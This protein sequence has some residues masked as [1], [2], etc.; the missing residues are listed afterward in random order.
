M[1][2]VQVYKIL[3]LNCLVSAYM[4]S[5]LYLFGIKQGD[6]QVRYSAPLDPVPQG[7]QHQLICNTTPATLTTCCF[8]SHTCADDAAG[9]VSGGALFL[10]LTG[11]ATRGALR[12]TTTLTHLLR[13]GGPIPRSLSRS[14]KLS[15]THLA[16]LLSVPSPYPVFIGPSLPCGFVS[17]VQ[18]CVSV[19]LQFI[20]HLTGLLM[21][22]RMVRPHIRYAL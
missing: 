13:T 19:V 2:A 10:R 12:R 20:V 5:S 11:R 8:P 4:L 17:S 7:D 21:T 9:P 3:A 6:L 16:S 1:A 14:A 18:V 15:A 22:M